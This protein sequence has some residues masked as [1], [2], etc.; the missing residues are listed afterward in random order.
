MTKTFVVRIISCASNASVRKSKLIKIKSIVFCLCLASALASV[1]EYN[2]PSLIFH[3]APSGSELGLG[4]YFGPDTGPKGGFYDS[5]Y[6]KSYEKEY[7][8]SKYD[9][10]HGKPKGY[11]FDYG[12]SDPHTGDHKKV[13]EVRIGNVVKG[14]YTLI[15]PDG[16]ERIVEYTAD[17]VH[18]FNAVVKRIKP[19]GYPDI[20]PY[21]KPYPIL[22]VI[23]VPVPIPAAVAPVGPYGPLSDAPYTPLYK[24]YNYGER[25][26]GAYS[27]QTIEQTH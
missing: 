5:D 18:G 1:D 9:E 15:E 23:P 21:D 26:G 22:P 16:T 13:W 25:Y 6:E 10:Y 14:G 20:V 11:S 24:D 4:S 12:V 2:R 27:Y 8:G 17:D 19:S 3:G 7:D